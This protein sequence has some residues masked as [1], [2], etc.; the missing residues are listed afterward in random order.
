MTMLLMFLPQWTQ[1]IQC[2]RL[3]FFYTGSIKLS[4]ADLA[5]YFTNVGLGYMKK[6]DRV[7]SRI[8]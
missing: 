3:S 2:Y 8:I 7:V 6:S 4:M 1:R 5:F